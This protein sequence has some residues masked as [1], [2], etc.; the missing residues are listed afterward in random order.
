[1]KPKA[2]RYRISDFG[3]MLLEV[4]QFGSKIWRCQYQ[5]HKVHQPH[6]P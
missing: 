5:L 1:V 2:V 6:S 3:G 4:M